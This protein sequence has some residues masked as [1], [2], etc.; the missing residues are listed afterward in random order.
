MAANSAELQAPSGGAASRRSAWPV[1][2]HDHRS[3]RIPW[4]QSQYFAPACEVQF[5]C[6]EKTVIVRQQEALAT[7]W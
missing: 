1:I 5:A 4:E 6:G 2:L 3:T 7:T